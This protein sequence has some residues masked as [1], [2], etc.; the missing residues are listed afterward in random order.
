MKFFRILGKNIADSFKG[1]VREIGLSFTTTWSITITLIVVAVAMVV[2]YNVDNFS[3]GFKEEMT[4]VT[5]LPSSYSKEES[6][7]FEEKLKTITNINV[8]EIEYVSK[9]DIAQDM[10]EE[11][12]TLGG[13]IGSWEEGENPLLDSY[14]VKVNDINQIK[15]TSEAIRALDEKIITKYGEGMVEQLVVVVRVV[16]QVAYVMVVALVLVTAFLIGNTIK[17]TIYSRKREIEIMRLVG[18]SNFV[19]KMPFMLEGM[20]LG[21]IGA[22][23]P[24]AITIYGYN[25]FYTFFEGKLFSPFIELVPVYPFVYIVSGIMLVIAIVVGTMGSLR[26]VRRHLKIW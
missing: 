14:V 22:I 15:N 12:S 2:S 24:I 3:K 7:A 10:M 8:N 21:I 23:I 11:S 18:A 25:S 1:I 17:L 6:I 13:I 16:E 4:I 9:Y 20:I 19:I 26:A 5:F